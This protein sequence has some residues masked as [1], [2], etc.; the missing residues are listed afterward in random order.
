MSHGKWRNFRKYTGFSCQLQISAARELLFGLNFRKLLASDFCACHFYS[1]QFWHF[2]PSNVNVVVLICHFGFKPEILHLGHFSQNFLLWNWSLNCLS[3]VK[4]EF[5]LPSVLKST[6]TAAVAS[7][8][9]LPGRKVFLPHEGEKQGRK[10]FCHSFC[11]FC[12]AE[13]AELIKT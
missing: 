13:R 10:Y 9:F 2:Q 12:R 4:L 1:P 8:G 6:F 7:V 3:T 11:H 5:K